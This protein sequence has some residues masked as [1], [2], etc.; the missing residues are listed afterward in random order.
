MCVIFSPIVSLIGFSII[1]YF[2]FIIQDLICFVINTATKLL[3]IYFHEYF[4]K[5]KL[6]INIGELFHATSEKSEHLKI[7]IVITKI[8]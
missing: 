2:S 3:H 1:F 6:N 8:F 7:I 5:M 4:S